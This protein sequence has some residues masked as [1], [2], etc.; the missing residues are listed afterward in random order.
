MTS[1]VLPTPARAS[2]P[3]GA[4]RRAFGA[5][6][7]SLVGLAFAF[8][9]TGCADMMGPRTLSISESELTLL[10]ARQ[11]PMERKVLEVIDLQ[12]AN[13]Q[14]H[15]LPDRNRVG[16]ELDVSALDRLFGTRAQGH[17]QLDYALRFEPSDHSIRMSQVRVRDLS[18]ESGSNSLHGTA[19]RMGTLVAEN[20]L[21]NMAVYKMKPGQA[22]TMDRLNLVAGPITV[23]PQGIQMTISPRPN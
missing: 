18:L 19:Q 15:L 2:R 16:T 1:H 23:T 14:I 10:L 8:G 7:A 13:P 11:F 22:D 9:A 6:L 21:E 20:V 12:V 4:G 17:V 3:S 5:A